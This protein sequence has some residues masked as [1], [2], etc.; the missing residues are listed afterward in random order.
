MAHKV[1]LGHE[2]LSFPESLCHRCDAPPKYIRTANSI[3][4]LC[5]L[6]ANKYP[7]QPVLSCP[8][9]RP[10]EGEQGHDRR[11]DSDDFPDKDG[12]V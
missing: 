9:F 8:R 1:R 3:F 5:P 7:R 12:E 4:V 10:A 2:Q 11:L 6:L